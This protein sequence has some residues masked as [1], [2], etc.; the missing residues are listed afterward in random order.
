MIRCVFMFLYSYLVILNDTINICNYTSI[1]LTIS[2]L[3]LSVHP[4]LFFHVL[5]SIIEWTDIT[6]A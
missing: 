3:L 6:N 2:N 1:K 4:F 5:C